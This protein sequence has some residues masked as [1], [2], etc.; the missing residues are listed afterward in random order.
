M[1]DPAALR[2]VAVVRLAS[3]Q[4]HALEPVLDAL[5]HRGFPFMGP[6]EHGGAWRCECGPL[7]L[8][9]GEEAGQWTVSLPVADDNVVTRA[10]LKTLD[11]A[12]RSLPGAAQVEWYKREDRGGAPAS[13]PIQS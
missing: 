12:L 9:F 11:E 5:T 4:W 7:A 6:V 1:G 10:L 3:R 8:T 2:T 13:S